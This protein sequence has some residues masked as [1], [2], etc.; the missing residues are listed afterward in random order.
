MESKLLLVYL[1]IVLVALEAARLTSG[2]VRPD[3]EVLPLPVAAAGLAL[4]TTFSITIMVPGGWLGVLG[5][6]LPPDAVEG[7]GLKLGWLACLSNRPFV[8]GW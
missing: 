6:L 5:N 4:P 1:P 7:L 3:L 2:N 8:K